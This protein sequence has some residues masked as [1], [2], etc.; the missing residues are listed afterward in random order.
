M[1]YEEDLAAAI[2]A[3]TLAKLRPLRADLAPLTA[4]DRARKL[5]EEALDEHIPTREH[6]GYYWDRFELLVRR[7]IAEAGLPAS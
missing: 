1:S 3:S 6:H 2:R 7:V 4:S 5:I